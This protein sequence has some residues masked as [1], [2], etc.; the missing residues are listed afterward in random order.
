M[1]SNLEMT[2]A[3]FLE[4]TCTKVRKNEADHYT[5]LMMDN[6]KCIQYGKYQYYVPDSLHTHEEE[7]ISSFLTDNY[8]L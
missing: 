3:E 2:I 5:E 6:H 7:V 4:E 1:N 8:P